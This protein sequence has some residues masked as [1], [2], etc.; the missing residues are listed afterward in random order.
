MSLDVSAREVVVLLEPHILV[1]ADLRIVHDEEVPEDEVMPAEGVAPKGP[2]TAP[3]HVHA[4]ELRPRVICAA[5][6]R[7]NEP[8][9]GDGADDVTARGRV[10]G[11]LGVVGALLRVRTIAVLPRRDVVRDLDTSLAL[12]ACVLKSPVPRSR[13]LASNDRTEA[14]CAV[15]LHTVLVHVPRGRHARLGELRLDHKQV[16]HALKLLRPPRGN[17]TKVELIGL[18]QVLPLVGGED[19]EERR[20]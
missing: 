5:H 11:V 12:A 13:E 3:E 1:E 10:R 18:W 6:L 16:A 9:R 8:G 14:E 19:L 15:I 2:R 4:A 17:H 7:Q 20:V